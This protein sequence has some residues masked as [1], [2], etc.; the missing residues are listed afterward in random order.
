[1]VV[2]ER[3]PGSLKERLDV[4]EF[5]A[6]RQRVFR[7]RRSTLDL[8][9]EPYS[10]D[11]LRLALG[12]VRLGMRSEIEWL[13]DAAFEDRGVDRHGNEIWTA[14]QVVNHIGHTQIGM[15]SWLHQSLGLLSADD[16]HPLVNLTDADEPGRLTREQSLHVLDVAE[17]ELETM[18]DA[19]PDV[20]LPGMRA[21]HPA[22][23]ITGVKGGLL[24]MTIH[25]H[26][27]L[28]QLIDLRI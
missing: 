19:I 21:R 7:D 11:D 15:T 26:E 9:A 4:S 17:R 13:P 23:G 27:H 6:A 2:G 14:G 22:F 20:L 8:E 10:L 18:F 25:E 28:E 5:Q 3:R 16:D 24:I 1:V 12:V